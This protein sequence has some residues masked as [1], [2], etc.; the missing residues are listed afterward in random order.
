MVDEGLTAALALEPA[1]NVLVITN[2]NCVAGKAAG[3]SPDQ[4]CAKWLLIKKIQDARSGNE[5]PG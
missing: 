3:L 5:G 2:L 4:I 1:A